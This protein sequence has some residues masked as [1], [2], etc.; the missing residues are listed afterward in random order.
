MNSTTENTIRTQL[1]NLREEF[2]GTS[3]RAAAIVGAAVIDDLF[4]T[5]ISRSFI[6]S[7]QSKKIISNTIGNSGPLA[8]FSSKID[9]SYLLGL[10]SENERSCAHQIRQIRNEFAHKLE[11]HSFGDQSIADRCKNIVHPIAM[12]DPLDVY[13]ED[14]NLPPII[15]ITP[16]KI[17]DYRGIFIESVFIMIGK[18]TARCAVAEMFFLSL[19]E[20]PQEY[21]TSDAPIKD[22]IKNTEFFEDFMIDTLK[23]YPIP[24]DRRSYLQKELDEIKKKKAEFK[25]LEVISL[26]AIRP[27]SRC[28]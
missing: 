4:T 28:A 15:E 25:L 2:N 10:I 12:I 1:N 14:F 23:N 26:S 7:K 9:M 6:S 19:R 17:D 13:V 18:L 8:T 22:L 27:T 20:S 11:K 5:L 21:E 3:D 24:D 16:A